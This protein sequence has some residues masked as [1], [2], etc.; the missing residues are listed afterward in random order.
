MTA[1]DTDFHHAFFGGQ[2]SAR[3]T[4]SSVRTRAIDTGTANT[5]SST[6]ASK[7]SGPPEPGVTQVVV[8]DAHPQQSDRRG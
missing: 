4:H 1:L 3:D 8:R 5:V 2:P 6:W 7:W